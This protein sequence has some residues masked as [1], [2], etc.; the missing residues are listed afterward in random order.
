MCER[1]GT[2][3]LQY[4]AADGNV[5]KDNRECFNY[6]C[7][8]G[9]RAKGLVDDGGESVKNGRVVRGSGDVVCKGQRID[10]VRRRVGEEEEEGSTSASTCA[11]RVQL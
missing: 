2:S 9:V 5:Q 8:L 1:K 10:Q 7:S 11:L 3:C 6:D 4:A